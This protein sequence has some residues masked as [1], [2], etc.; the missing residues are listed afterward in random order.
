MQPPI[1]N[2]VHWSLLFLWMLLFLSLTNLNIAQDDPPSAVGPMLKMFKS[3]RLPAERQ[4]TVVEMICNRGNEHDL[5]VILDKILTPDAFTPELRQK[6][7]EWMVDAAATRKVKPTGQLDTI[8][9]LMATNDEKVKLA[10]IRLASAWKLDSFSQTLQEIATSGKSPAVLQQAAIEGLVALGG[11]NSQSTL[12]ALASGKQTMRVRK[13]AVTGLAKM[14]LNIASERAAQLFVDAKPADDP[15]TVLMAFFDRQGGSD[16][17]AEALKK[18]NLTVD[19]AKMALRYMY[20]IGRSDAELSNVLSAAAGIAADP[21]PPT[22][23]DVAK[24]VEEVITKGDAVRGEEIFRRPELSCMRCHGINRAGGQVGPD[25]SAIGGSSP[26][27][28]IVNSILNPNLA[29]KELYVTRVYLLEGGRIVTGVVVDQDDDRV[30]VRDSQGKTVTIAKAEIE[31]EAEGK[32]L[33]PQG[34]T[35]FLT[36]E[37]VVDL[38][39][40]ISELGKPGPFEIRKSPSIQLWRVMQNPAKELTESVPHLE[41]IRELVLGSSPEQWTGAYGKVSGVLPLNEL[42]PA[43]SSEVLILQGEIQINEPGQVSFTVTCSENCQLWMD[44][45]PIT[46]TK[47][48]T[49]NLSAGRHKLTVRV[50][51]SANPAPELHVGVSKPNDSTAQLEVVGGP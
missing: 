7:I 33:M 18:A 35:K 44:D 49:T 26:V 43:A 5:R 45:Q 41:N 28:Y 40:F 9:Q 3:G 13:M 36:H 47:Q 42:R 8:S 46:D 20:S 50:E 23:E 22:Q 34:L 14:D 16:R 39:K 10:A 32:S 6:A 48:F 21:P 12:V 19:I 38:I 11:A 29:V 31:D 27:D 4:G 15:Q 25:L 1:L 30:I 17:L 24:L 51:L 2:R 37:E